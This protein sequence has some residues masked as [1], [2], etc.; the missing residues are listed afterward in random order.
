LSATCM[1]VSLDAV[2]DSESVF[3]LPSNVQVRIVEA[4]FEKSQF[5]VSGCDADNKP[6][7]INGHLPWGVA[8]GL[9][10]TYVKQITVSYRGVSHTLDASDMYDAWGSRPL[11][12]EG[13]KLRYFGGRCFDENNCQFRGL[14]SDTS[15]SF[16]AEWRIVG[17]KSFR[18]VLTDSDDVKNLFD[19]NIDPPEYDE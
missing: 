6:C 1:L 17:G 18:T 8:F 13:T 14:F 2:A 4:P 15:G 5:S 10:R 3:T 12:Y 16:V 7:F 9:P 11:Q 19:K